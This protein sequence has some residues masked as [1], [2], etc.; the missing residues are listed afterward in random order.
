MLS[1][2]STVSF[3]AFFVYEMKKKW[4]TQKMEKNNESQPW[5]PLSMT[6]IGQLLATFKLL[7]NKG[8]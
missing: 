5:E 4:T 3:A 2:T 7:K 1:S 8:I 6:K